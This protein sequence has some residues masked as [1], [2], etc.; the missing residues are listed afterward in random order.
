MYFW[1]LTYVNLRYIFTPSPAGHQPANRQLR[2]PPLFTQLG[3]RP[4][5][6]GKV[7]STLIGRSLPERC[8]IDLG[9]WWQTINQLQRRTLAMK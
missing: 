5:Q 9:S 4:H 6:V 3:E 8:R 7:A 2:Q 1:Y